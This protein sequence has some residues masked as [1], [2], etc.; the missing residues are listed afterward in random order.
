MAILALGVL[1]SKYFLSKVQNTAAAKTQVGAFFSHLWKQS[2]AGSGNMLFVQYLIT[3]CRPASVATVVGGS[4]GVDSGDA[5][6]GGNTNWIVGG[7]AAVRIKVI[8]SGVMN[9]MQSREQ[10]WLETHVLC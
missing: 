10:L 4:G 3:S 8:C 9:V 5:V 6:P 2:A 7:T 1:S